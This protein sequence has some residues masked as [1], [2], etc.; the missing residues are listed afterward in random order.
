MKSVWDAPPSARSAAWV[1]VRGLLVPL[2]AGAAGVF[3]FAPFYLWPVAIV[4][5]AILFHV[6]NRSGSP[7]QAALSGFA[8]GLGY[9]LVGVSWMYVSLH[10]FGSMPA[11]LAAVAVFF[12]CAYLA[13][14]P[15]GTGWIALRF[16]GTRPGPRL[17]LMSAAF[18]ALEWLRGWF[19]SGF[20]WLTLGTSQAPASPLAGFAPL[21]GAYG[22]SLAVVLAAALI[23]ALFE[24]RLS[25]ARVA[26][27]I[28]VAV[29]F[30]SGGLA[31][32]LSWGEPS[33]EPLTIALLQGN[34]PQSL[35]W[36]DEV[37]AKTL[38]DYRD[39]VLAVKARVVVLPETSLPAFLDE[40]PRDYLE[41][42]RAHAR[43]ARKDILLGTVEREF[44]GG[45]DYDYYNSLVNLTD[46][47][48][49]GYRKRH[50]VPFGEYI[51]PG[52]KWILAVLQIPLSDFAS[53]TGK[54]Q[55]LRAAGRRFGVAICY[56]DIFG[57]EVIEL[58][59]EAEILVNV[60]N[61]AW[62]G[63][64]FAADQHLQAS[65]MRAL[66]AS[67]WMV[68]ATNTGATAAIDERGEVVAR[69]SAFTRG[70]LVYAVTPRT[71]STP[72]VRWGNY[73]ALALAAAL[74]FVALRAA[75]GRPQTH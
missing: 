35:K 11:P 27:A 66:E 33:G 71:G 28:A 15:A 14:F 46:P 7:L 58:L 3:A 38:A 69:L 75:R 31:K 44:R 37:R 67:R 41:E 61:D 63:E 6:W 34:V 17:L 26:L 4:V 42:L 36:R 60:S 54:P 39:M 13:A 43:E 24:T 51:P 50:L 12:V 1:L 45:R 2:A 68:R 18:V 5:M 40:L 32:R 57:E 16:G 47:G 59:P 19:L 62:F 65:Q 20:P 52:F 70:T 21:L 55:V 49:R 48:Q 29:I 25:R 22:T 72:Y 10:E 64:S 56:E 74:A 30:A 9:F 53:P 8:F 73:A 23:A